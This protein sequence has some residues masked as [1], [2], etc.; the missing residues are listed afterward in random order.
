MNVTSHFIFKTLKLFRSSAKTS[1]RPNRCGGRRKKRLENTCRSIKPKPKLI[2]SIKPKP[3]LIRSN[4]P[5]PKLIRS[6]KP[7]PKLI[8]SIKP[9]LNP[10]LFSGY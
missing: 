9:K 10:K 8:W 3:K 4:K 7:K 1:T 5:K 6:I 2:Q